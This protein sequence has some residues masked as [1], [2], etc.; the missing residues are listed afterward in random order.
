MLKLRPRNLETGKVKSTPRQAQALE[1]G[2]GV[3]HDWRW[4]F[5]RG[6]SVGVLEFQVFKVWEGTLS[7]RQ[8]TAEGSG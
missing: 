2:C 4:I 8:E 7:E 3:Q 6:K 1:I 5:V